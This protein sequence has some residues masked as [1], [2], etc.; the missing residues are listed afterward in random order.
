VRVSIFKSPFDPTPDR[1]LDIYDHLLDAY[2]RRLESESPCRISWV[3]RGGEVY[4]VPAP[5]DPVT[6]IAVGVAVV[7]LAVSVYTYFTAPEPPAGADRNVV[8]ST[9]PTNELGARSNRLRPKARVPE[10]F[11]TQRLVP[12][13]I[14]IPYSVWEDGVEVST[15][16]MCIGRGEYDVVD[17]QEGD[18]A[19]ESLPGYGAA[20]YGP[21]TWPGSGIPQYTVGDAPTDP[22]YLVAQAEMPADEIPPPNVAFIV[23]DSDIRANGLLNRIE[24]APG[25]PYDFTM[26]FSL[27]DTVRVSDLFINLQDVSGTYTVFNVGT[28]FIDVTPTTWINQVGSY[29]SPTLEKIDSSWG[30][31]IRITSRGDL[32]LT[33]FVVHGGLWYRQGGGSLG[34]LFVQ[35]EL[36]VEPVDSA[37]T[38]TGPAQVVPILLSGVSGSRSTVAHT[39]SFSPAAGFGFYRLRVRRITDRLTDRETSDNVLW[40]NTYVMSSV[41]GPFGDTTLIHLKARASDALAS[42]QLKFSALASRKL[43]GWDGSSYAAPIAATDSAAAAAAAICFDPFVGGLDP[44]AIDQSSLRAAELAVQAWFEYADATAF[45]YVF[46]SEDLSFEDMLLTA[47]RAGFMTAYRDGP[48]IRFRPDIPNDPSLLLNHRVVVPGSPKISVQLGAAE[49]DHD[50][51]ELWYKDPETGESVEVLAPDHDAVVRPLKMQTAGLQDPRQARLHAWRERNRRRYLRVTATATVTAEG[52]LAQAGDTVLLVD[53]TRPGTIAGE[54]LDVTG[55][56]VLLDRV[57]DITLPAT[58]YVQLVNGTVDGVPIVSVLG[59]TVTLERAFLGGVTLDRTSYAPAVYSIVL[60]EQGDVLLRMRVTERQAS[61]DGWNLTLIED[62]FMVFSYD[63]LLL[64][65]PLN[66]AIDWGPIDVSVTDDPSTMYVLDVDRGSFV[67]EGAGL[68]LTIAEVATLNPFTFSVRV[69]SDTSGYLFNS[70]VLKVSVDG[71]GGVTVGGG[72]ANL[73]GTVPVGWSHIVVV[74]APSTLSLYVDGVLVDSDTVTVAGTAFPSLL[75]AEGRASDLRLW[76]VAL[77]AD[78]VALF[79]AETFAPVTS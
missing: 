22:P 43:P 9:A 64:W 28:S 35:I 79:S 32:I 15:S 37:G 74:V 59:Q 16:L 12:D 62:S 52:E 57:W 1:V 78:E 55:T 38:P 11:G 49:G 17:L 7:S 30:P 56:S 46:D 33:S 34:G 54:L 71:V 3:E 42:G 27:G 67:R 44:S 70:G 65:L 50:S 18:T 26:V 58:M 73:T 20:V 6:A 68:P 45:N 76:F 41:S 25:A 21:G 53:T 10:A 24:M 36:E 8:D 51:V 40:R 75:E 31:S 23:G 5:E 72:G 13:L 39:E 61:N 4:V 66:E 60:D 63:H 29:M 77:D 2:K 19:L 14:G 47:L 48:T 69:R